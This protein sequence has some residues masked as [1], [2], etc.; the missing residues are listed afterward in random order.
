MSY[1]FTE[2]EIFTLDDTFDSL[3][4]DSLSD[5]EGGTIAFSADRTADEKKQFV[6]KLI[7]EQNYNN[8]KNIIVAKDG[9]TCMYIQGRFQD[10]T[11]TW[12]NGLVGKINDSKAWTA[13]S[14]FHQAN[15]DW[16]LSLGGDSW[17]IETIKG[18]AIDTFFTMMN[19]NGICLGTL[20]EIDLEDNMKQMKW[21][22]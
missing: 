19:D 12:M 21:T 15:K 6:I 4:T 17:A 22:Y 10:N 1:T 5:I 3:Y 14:T 16:I 9:T 2:T 13:T 20:E 7:N 8:M 18:T 11:Y